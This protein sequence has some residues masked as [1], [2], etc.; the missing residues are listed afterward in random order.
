MYSYLARIKKLCLFIFVAALFSG[1]LFAQTNFFSPYAVSL[2]VADSAVKEG[3]IISFSKETYILSIVPNDVDIYGV[4]VP[5]SL[6]TFVDLNNT[7]G[8]FVSSGGEASVNVS[9]LN[10][11]IQP[12]DF[13]TSST[14]PGVGMKSTNP[15]QIVGIALEPYSAASVDEV[16]KIKV[17]VSIKTNLVSSSLGGNLLE[18]IGRSLKSPFMTPIEALRYLLAIGV[19][20]AAFVIGFSSFGRITGTSVEALGRNPLAS[21]SIKKVILFNFVL[22]AIIM[23]VGLSIAYFIL[24]I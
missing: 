7:S 22:T 3:D 6:T 2:P 8:K 24:V 1:K 11:S 4:V 15:G 23:L 18:T 19:V 10:G 17:F 13:I 9:T 16:G 5:T 20:L 21:S 12:G 14:K